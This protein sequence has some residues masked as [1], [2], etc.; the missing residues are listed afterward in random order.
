MHTLLDF[1]DRSHLSGFEKVVAVERKSDRVMTIVMTFE[2]QLIRLICCYAPQS[3]RAE[4]DKELFMR[5]YVVRGQGAGTVSLF[6]VWAILMGMWVGIVMV[7][8]AFMGGLVL[9]RG[10]WK[11][12]YC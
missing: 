6:L 11:V 1:T 8:R 12:G 3:G 2:G 5:I 9:V 7:S 10:T 4:S